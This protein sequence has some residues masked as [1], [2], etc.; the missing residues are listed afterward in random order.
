MKIY[1]IVTLAKA[2]HSRDPYIQSL[3]LQHS[4]GSEEKGEMVAAK[5]WERNEGGSRDFYLKLAADVI[6]D[7]EKSHAVLLEKSQ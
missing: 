1:V 7:M 6:A 3:I 5:A 2:L 4:E